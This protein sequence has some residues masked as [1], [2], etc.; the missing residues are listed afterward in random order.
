[1]GKSSAV[2]TRELETLADT[3]STALPPNAA[4]C[5]RSRRSVWR[6]WRDDLVGRVHSVMKPAVRPYAG[7]V[8]VGVAPSLLADLERAWRW[9]DELD[10]LT[11]ELERELAAVQAAVRQTRTRA[12]GNGHP[13]RGVDA[14]TGAG[15]RRPG[16]PAGRDLAGAAGAEDHR[17]VGIQ[18]EVLAPDGD[19]GPGPR[20][21]HRRARVGGRPDRQRQHGA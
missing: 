1:M 8:L 16:P 20:L 9:A 2:T 11:D 17:R 14:R 10:D 5:D 6:A 18:R 12:A 3:V 19:R 4:G 13:D 21:A 7:K 15:P